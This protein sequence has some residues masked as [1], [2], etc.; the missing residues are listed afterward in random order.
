MTKE[1][2]I[3]RIKI[4]ADRPLVQIAG[5]CVIESEAATLRHA[6][7]LLTIFKVFCLAVLF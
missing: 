2:S 6:E 5:P 3:D 7:R 1:I 4:G